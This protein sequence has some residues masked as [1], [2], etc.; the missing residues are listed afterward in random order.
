[1]AKKETISQRI[2]KWLSPRKRAKGYAEERKMKIHMY[3]PKEGQELSEYDKGL[4]SGYLMCQSDHAGQF[5]YQQALNAG[6]SK[7]EAAEISRTI[8]K[9]K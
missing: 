7:K 6:K 2:R 3:G 9:N 1:M 4:R 5:K 8:G